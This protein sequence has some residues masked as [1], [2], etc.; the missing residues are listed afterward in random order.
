MMQKK[1]HM[2]HHLIVKIFKWLKITLLSCCVML[3]SITSASNTAAQPQPKP[4]YY[5]YYDAQGRV[6]IS[7]NVSPEHIRHGYEVLDRNMFLIKKVPAYNLQKDLSQ[8][9]ARASQLRET[10]QDQQIKR[11]YRNVK[12]ATEKKEDALKLIQKQ[13]SDHYLRMKQLQSDR[14]EFLTKKS[15]LIFN[16]QP[17]PTSLQKNLDSNE[18]NIK[19]TRQNIEMLKTQLAHQETFY[20]DIINRLQKME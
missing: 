4:S 2:Q 5:R 9:T 15:D 7:R 16:K 1:S 6:T 12:Y 10:Q 3:P 11:S 8:S 18:A 20:N 13:I 17:I 19:Q 14:A